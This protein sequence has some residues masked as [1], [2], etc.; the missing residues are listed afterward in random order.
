MP[1]ASLSIVRLLPSFRSGEIVIQSVI[2]NQRSS[3]K[4]NFFIIM[5]RSRYVYLEILF[6]FLFQEILKFIKV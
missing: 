2:F 6:L 4:L 5:L 3:K 1:A